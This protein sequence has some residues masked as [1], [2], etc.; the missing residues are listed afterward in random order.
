MQG[1]RSNGVRI[2]DKNEHDNRRS[3]SCRLENQKAESFCPMDSTGN[4]L[5][6]GTCMSTE[7]DLPEQQSC[8]AD[9]GRRHSGHECTERF[10]RP[11][12]L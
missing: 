3:T 1:S 8:V 6:A 11:G 9:G 10:A 2:G 4:A 5:V 7:L 12:I